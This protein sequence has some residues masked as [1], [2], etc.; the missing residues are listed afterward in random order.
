[1]KDNGILHRYIGPEN[2]CGVSFLSEF[3]C[4]LHGSS[5]LI[6]IPNP[7]AVKDG[8]IDQSFL[9]IRI[10]IGK[11]ERDLEPYSIDAFPEGA[12]LYGKRPSGISCLHYYG[13]DV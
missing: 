9:D 8:A 2:D 5:D 1:M 4:S 13:L 7:H 10:G 12:Y 6:E 3:L 11:F